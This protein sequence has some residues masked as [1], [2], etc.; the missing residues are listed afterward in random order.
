MS[1]LVTVSGAAL[2]APRPRN[3]FSTH[4]INGD[5]DHVPAC[6]CPM[7]GGFRALLTC[8]MLHPGLSFSLQLQRHQTFPRIGL[9]GGHCGR[10]RPLICSPNIPIKGFAFTLSFNLVV[11]VTGQLMEINT[12]ALLVY[13]RYIRELT[14]STPVD[15][16]QQNLYKGFF[17]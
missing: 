13:H 11:E 15:V 10:L 6:T 4:A 1:A 2:V 8:S 12:P 14:Y 9:I 5:A 17:T 7:W 16:V 3:N